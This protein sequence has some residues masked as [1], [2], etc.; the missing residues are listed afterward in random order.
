MQNNFKL[1]DDTVSEKVSIYETYDVTTP[2]IFGNIDL[3]CKIS[4]TRKKNED[5][6]VLFQN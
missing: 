1:H 4:I 3:V 5:M 6:D 2:C